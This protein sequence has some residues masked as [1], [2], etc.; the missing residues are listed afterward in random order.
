MSEIII[1]PFKMFFNCTFKRLV[2]VVFYV[3][4][5]IKKKKNCCKTKVVQQLF[6]GDQLLGLEARAWVW[7]AWV[8]RSTRMQRALAGIKKRSAIIQ[9]TGAA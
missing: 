4:P 6:F 5:L 2:F 9:A 8:R 7:L 1:P 3:F